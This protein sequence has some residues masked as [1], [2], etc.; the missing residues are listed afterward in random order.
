MSYAYQIPL[1][2]L[3]VKLSE[4]RTW[5]PQVLSILSEPEMDH[6]IRKQLRLCG[7]IMDESQKLTRE[8]EG[9]MCT[10]S[11]DCIS[12]QVGHISQVKVDRSVNIHQDDNVQL[13]SQKVRKAQEA[14]EEQFEDQIMSQ[15]RRQHELISK[16]EMSLGEEFNQVLNHVYTQALEIRARQMGEI[17]SMR[18]QE[19]AQGNL[20]I[21]IQLKT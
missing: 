15:K 20:E 4:E 7:W 3:S 10:L 6:L 18:H 2:T 5:K 11:N 19:D 16:V 8:I 1:K 21:V 17:I 9:C 12:V 14:H 13:R